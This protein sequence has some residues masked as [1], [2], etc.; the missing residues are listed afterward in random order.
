MDYLLD[1]WNIKIEQKFSQVFFI[2]LYRL[3]Q[4]QSILYRGS[5]HIS[6]LFCAF[7]LLWAVRVIQQKK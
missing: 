6:D 4:S 1:L 7:F 3:L 2:F 5:T